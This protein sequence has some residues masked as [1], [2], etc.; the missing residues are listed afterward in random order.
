MINFFESDVS[1]IVP[2]VDKDIE[3]SSSISEQ[4]KKFKQTKFYKYAMKG[5]KIFKNFE[6]YAPATLAYAAIAVVL[7]EPNT[8]GMGMME[9]LLSRL[10]GSFKIGYIAFDGK[11]TVI[12]QILKIVVSVFSFPVALISLISSWCVAA[13]KGLF[14]NEFSLLD[15]LGSGAI[16]CVICAIAMTMLWKIGKI[17]YKKWKAR[18]IKKTL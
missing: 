3:S 18:K 12:F 2:V 6:I 14:S 8:Y 11:N 13:F 1:S 16:L 17:L 5:L 15:K 9:E 4:T 10:V 7:W